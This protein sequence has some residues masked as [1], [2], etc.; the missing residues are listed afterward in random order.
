MSRSGLTAA[1]PGRARARWMLAV[2]AIMAVLTIGWPLLNLAVSN[3]QKLAPY[4]NLTVG[5]SKSSDG[6]VTVGP[7]WTLLT[8]QS[9]PE[10]VFSIR[11]GGATMTISY[12]ALINAS[13]TPDLYAGL[14][15]LVQ[16]GHPGAT[17]SPPMPVVTLAGHRGV[18]GTITG[19]DLV[20]RAAAFPGPS[21]MFAIEM[22]V[23][24]P[25]TITMANVNAARLIML[26][27]TFGPPGR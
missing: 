8:A 5:T 14:R 25:V 16:V 4:T 12:V 6:T 27:L 13:Q 23:T 11:R 7:G 1:V 2:I 20:G 3:R 9:N 26:S 21:R 17:M 18:M 10:Q 15:K 22:V 19:D 24:A